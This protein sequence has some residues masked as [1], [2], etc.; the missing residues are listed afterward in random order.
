MKKSSIFTI[1]HSTRQIDEFVELLQM[2]AVKEVVDVRSIA[3]RLYH[4]AAI[5]HSSLMHLSRKDGWYGISLVARL[6]QNI[7]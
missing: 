4:G 5:V 1:G 7:G 3:L 2:H 6:P